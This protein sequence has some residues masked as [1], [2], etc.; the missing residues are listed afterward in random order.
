MEC[1]DPDFAAFEM[2]Y[3]LTGTDIGDER[4]Q[5][6]L[7]VSR[8]RVPKIRAGHKSTIDYSKL[9]RKT[10]SKIQVVTR[11]PHHGGEVLKARMCP[12]KQGLIASL[13]SVG[14]INMY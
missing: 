7:Q 3:F 2:N 12:K 5:D 6:Y 1:R 4:Q 14:L 10:H 8:I 13:N 11:I 9:D